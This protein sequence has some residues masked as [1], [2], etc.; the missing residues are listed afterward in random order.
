M[1][2]TKTILVVT[3]DTEEDNWGQHR[4]GITCDN[5]QEIPRLQEIFDRY[6]VIPT[7]LVTYQVC[8]DKKATEILS[9]IRKQGKCEIGAHLHPW[10][11]PPESEDFTEQNSMLKNLPQA[12]QQAKLQSLS[13]KIEGEFGAKPQ[14]FR[15][16]RWGLGPET[17]DVLLNCGFIVDTSVTPTISWADEGNGPVYNETLKEPYFLSPVDREKNNHKHIL[18]IPAT[19]GFNRWPFEFWNKVYSIAE[20]KRLK[21][22]K[23]LGILNRTSIL[24][25]IWL[26]PDR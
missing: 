9:A 17:I 22:L 13:E 19:I 6:G 8:Q 11:T 23:L 20:K 25:K 14:S 7:Y 2:N 16:G 4:S 1:S 10:N 26:Y 15:A 21:P 5:I 3:I 12:L 18:E 24:R